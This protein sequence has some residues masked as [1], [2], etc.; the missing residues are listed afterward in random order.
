MDLVQ[1]LNLGP[2]WQASDSVSP[3]TTE[4]ACRP[5]FEICTRTMSRWIFSGRVSRRIVSA[6]PSVII[7]FSLTTHLF[8]LYCSKLPRRFRTTLPLELLYAR[9]SSP[10]D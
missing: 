6:R 9:E 3:R 4:S 5:F 1:I 2:I 8:R 10:S 7:N